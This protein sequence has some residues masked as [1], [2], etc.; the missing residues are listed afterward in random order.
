MSTLPKKI[1]IMCPLRRKNYYGSVGGD[2]DTTTKRKNTTRPPSGG[3]R[4]S[5]GNINEH[6]DCLSPSNLGLPP[7]SSSYVA[8]RRADSSG[9]V[10]SESSR[11]SLSKNAGG[12]ARKSSRRRAPS[13]ST[14][15]PQLPSLLLHPLR[16]NRGPSPP[17]AVRRHLTRTVLAAPPALKISRP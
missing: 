17:P 9:S 13:P 5:S 4:S 7:K 6:G 10:A 1:P 16:S 12:G 2:V 11:G 14:V 8:R 3:R 15:P